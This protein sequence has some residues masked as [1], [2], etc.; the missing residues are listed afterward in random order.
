M[1]I[2]HVYKTSY[3]ASYGGVEKFIDGICR[4]GSDFGQNNIVLTL[5]DEPKPSAIQMPG[6]TVVQAKQN[7][8]IS[9]TGFSFSAF[10]RFKELAEKSDI[11]HY[12]YPNPFGD[13]LEL[14]SAHKKPTV[15]TYHS[16]IVRQNRLLSAYKP[17]QT[18]FLR[19]A[20]KIIATS[21]NYLDTSQILQQYKN[22]VSVIPIGLQHEQYQEPKVDLIHYWRKRMSK[23]FFLFV[24]ALRYY[25]GLHTLLESIS[26]T[27]VQVVIAG[28][29]SMEKN[30]KQKAAALNLTNLKFLGA[31][32]DD[33][34]VA[35]LH[36]CYG[37]VF[38]SNL[39]S[40]AFGIALLEAAAVGKPLISCEIGTGTSYININK[41]T[42]FVVNP[43]S[44]KELLQAMQFLLH[45]P[46][47]AEQLG[48]N[49]KKRFIK[50]FRA[51]QQVK[52]YHEIYSSI[53]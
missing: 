34:K 15:I 19:S 7:F 26:K 40:E 53:L 25:K 41:E 3:P 10:K 21:P 38:P 42:G 39:R 32:T 14:A 49:A 8:F 6:Y 52:S 17:L 16:D 13:L 33:D 30:L 35:L 11:I 27:D 4:F 5:N 9:S 50:H 18:Y 36:L 22:K 1:N 44:P 37:F 45:N 47:E 24:G 23:P 46:I 2:L 28:T 48:A 43:N 12:H 51:Y 29:G 20:E 31:I